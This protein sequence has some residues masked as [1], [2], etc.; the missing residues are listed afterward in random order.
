MIDR[1]VALSTAA[2]WGIALGLVLVLVGLCLLLLE[3]C[4]AL[5]AKA[6][7]PQGAL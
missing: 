2:Q 6:Q 1:Y 3:A 4:C 7:A 5:V